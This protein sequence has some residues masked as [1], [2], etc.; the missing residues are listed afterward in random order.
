MC[1][2]RGGVVGGG[3]ILG[4]IQTNHKHKSKSLQFTTSKICI[5]VGGGEAFFV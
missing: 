5:T 4:V 2:A 1:V 3:G